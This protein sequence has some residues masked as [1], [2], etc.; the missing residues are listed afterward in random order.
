LTPEVGRRTTFLQRRRLVL[1]PDRVEELT[2][3]P[4]ELEVRRMFFD[5]ISSATV[6]RRLLWTELVAG[7]LNVFVGLSL[8]GWA[9]EDRLPGALGVGAVLLLAGALLAVRALL[10]PTRVLVLRA[11]S[12]RMETHLPRWRHAQ[13]LDQ[14]VRSIERFQLE[15][16]MEGRFGGAEAAFRTPGQP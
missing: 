11:G 9:L 13:R 6:H 4:V 8:V 5:E 10:Q 1:Y 3:T 7:V 12:Q 16:R 2:A 14:L 15:A